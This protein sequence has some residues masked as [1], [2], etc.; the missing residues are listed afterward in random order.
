[1]AKAKAG[2]ADDALQGASV[3][4]LVVLGASVK[5]AIDP[6]SVCSMKP[7]SRLFVAERVW[8]SATKP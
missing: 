7:K 6:S 1:M 5:K 2:P 3:R 8:I 4:K